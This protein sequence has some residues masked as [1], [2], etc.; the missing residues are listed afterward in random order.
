MIRRPPRSTQSRSSAASDVYKRQVHLDPRSDHRG[1]QPRRLLWRHPLEDDGHQESGG[2]VV[3]ERAVGDAGDEE[4]DSLAGERGAVPLG[5]DDIGGT[6]RAKYT[7]GTDHGES[8]TDAEGS[9]LTQKG[10]GLTQKGRGLPATPKS[11]SDEGGTQRGRN[12]CLL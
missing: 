6:H 7:V 2:L 3:R 12:C 5:A 8:G 1:G 9:V 4:V 10:R 11:R